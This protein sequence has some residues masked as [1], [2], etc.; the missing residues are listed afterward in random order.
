MAYFFDEFDDEGEK[1]YYRRKLVKER[2]Y[3]G[4][5]VMSSYVNRYIYALTLNK[6]NPELARYD[7]TSPQARQATLAY[8]L[9]LIKE[10]K[11]KVGRYG[12][13][14]PNGIIPIEQYEGTSE[15][16]VDR[17]QREWNSCTSDVKKKDEIMHYMYYETILLF[18]LAENPWPIMRSSRPLESM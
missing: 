10:K 7:R 5:D 6:L 11:L 14:L 12:T 1:E 3:V 16:I 15:E 13:T 17:I 2:G 4:L 9:P 18:T 8:L